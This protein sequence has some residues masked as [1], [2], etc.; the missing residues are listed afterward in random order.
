MIICEASLALM[1]G[2]R[3]ILHR[4]LYLGMSNVVVI[5]ANTNTLAAPLSGRELFTTQNTPR[6]APDKRLH[7]ILTA[8]EAFHGSQVSTN[9]SVSA[10][11]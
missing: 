9:H 8:W 3:R 6:Q 11:I 5:R 4:I 1:V 7:N 10:G 2:L